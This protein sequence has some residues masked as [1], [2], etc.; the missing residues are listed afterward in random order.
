MAHLLNELKN[1]KA[2]NEKLNERLQKL[3]SKLLAQENAENERV[4]LD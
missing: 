2:E 4:I 1:V 3:E